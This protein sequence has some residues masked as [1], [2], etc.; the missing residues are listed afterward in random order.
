MSNITFIDL[1]Y[2]TTIFSIQHKHQLDEIHE[3]NY[4]NR[5]NER[6][7]DLCKYLTSKYLDN[8]KKSM[9]YNAEL[10]KFELFYNFDKND[11]KANFPGLGT[12]KQICIYW[13]NCLTIDDHKF[14]DGQM[15]LKGINFDVWGNKK[16]TTKFS[17][18]KV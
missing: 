6:L 17:W 12:P 5:K 10:G 1:I 11:F 4:L 2:D 15:S 8:I 7:E 3:T 16:F 9:M 18:N 13:L 14:L